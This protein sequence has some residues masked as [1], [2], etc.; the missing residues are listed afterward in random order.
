MIGEEGKASTFFSIF[1]L[2]ASIAYLKIGRELVLQSH[3]E[4]LDV[5]ILLSLAIAGTFSVGCMLHMLLIGEPSLK[6]FRNQVISEADKL[7]DMTDR[8]LLQLAKFENRRKDAKGGVLTPTAIQLLDVSR[9]V[10]TAM[11]SRANY[12][13]ELICK[14]TAHSVTKAHELLHAPLHVENDSSTAL[15]T[16]DPIPPL[17]AEQLVAYLSR[18]FGH[19]DAELCKMEA[20]LLR[21]KNASI[22]Q[23]HWEAAR[24]QIAYSA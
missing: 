12:V 6:N 3:P 21:K 8:S 13:D 5:L 15:I 2:L 17:D 20:V 11:Q 23:N 10:T 24:P 4:I 9:Q 18:W 14:S 22:P 19:I 7:C 1:L 16:T